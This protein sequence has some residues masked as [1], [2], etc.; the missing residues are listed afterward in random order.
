M[1][2]IPR[3]SCVPNETIGEKEI[4][5]L[6]DKAIEIVKNGYAGRIVEECPLNTKWRYNFVTEQEF[7][8]QNNQNSFLV[9]KLNS[10]KYVRSFRDVATRQWTFALLAENQKQKDLK[11]ELIGGT[12]AVGR[13]NVSSMIIMPQVDADKLCDFII[14]HAPHIQ[15]IQ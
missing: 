8:I 12:R 13:L 7:V 1:R 4:A 10:I 15:K 2:R 6:P 14:K 11:V 9:F 3:A 5:E